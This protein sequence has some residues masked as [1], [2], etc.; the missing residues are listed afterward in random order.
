VLT[1]RQPSGG[2]CERTLSL[3]D[4]FR[5]IV[6]HPARQAIVYHRPMGAEQMGIDVTLLT[7]IYYKPNRFPYSLAKWAP[8][9][10]RKALIEL[11]E[12]RR[13]PGLSPDNVVTILGPVFEGAYRAGVLSLRRWWKTW[14]WLAARWIQ[15]RC[16]RNPRHLVLLHCFIECSLRTL[17]VARSKGIIR[18]LEVT[19]PPLLADNGQMKEWGVSESDFPNDVP[20]LKQELAEADFVLVQSEFGVR[21]IQ[22]LGFPA[23]RILRIHLGVDTDEFQPRVGARMPG[24]LRVVFVGQLN[25][26]K[27]VHHLL[28]AW[29]ELN[30][31]NA[32]LLLAGNT[33]SAPAELLA[34]ITG[35]PHCRSLGHLRKHELVSFYQQADILVHP[36]LAEGGCAAIYEALSCG[37]PCIVSNHSTSAV[38]PGIEGRVFPVGDVQALKKA[39]FELATDTGLRGNMA[40]SARRRAEQSLS[41]AA[42]SR[43]I[44]DLYRGVAKASENPDRER[45]VEGPLVTAF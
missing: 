13:M 17:R 2:R 38:R 31:E 40:E 43:E 42:F 11:L 18:L 45:A 10:K 3:K 4:N 21:T 35:T 20:G 8:A 22:S 16:R 24:P 27:G 5:V 19:L 6:S 34:S 41:L 39:I 29:S 9:R 23:S 25:R 12:L 7:G 1:D 15:L 14:D 33:M 36:S 30:L 37:V 44:A 28:R 32:E 26:R